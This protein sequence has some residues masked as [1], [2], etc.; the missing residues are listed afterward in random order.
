MPNRPKLGEKELRGH[1]QNPPPPYVDKHE[2]FTNPPPPLLA[3]GV[4]HDPLPIA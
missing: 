4:V 1:F 2:H 3:T